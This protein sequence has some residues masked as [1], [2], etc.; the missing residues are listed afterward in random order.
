MKTTSLAPSPLLRIARLLV[1]LATSLLPVHHAAAQ[2]TALR[3]SGLRHFYSAPY[4]L[5]FN[6]A[7]R[8]Q[9]NRVV[10]LDPALF[11][12]VCRESATPISAS[13]TGFRL[14]ADNK[15]LECFVVL[16]YTLS[17]LDPV[18]NGDA[19]GDFKSD[20]VEA[21]EQGAKTLL[22]VLREDA[23]VG[24]YE[25]HRADAGF[26]PQKVADLMRDKAYLTNQI[27]GIWNEVVWTS[28]STRCWDA[29]YMA[30][31]EFPTDNPADD[32][33]FLVF[34]SD[35]KDESSTHTANEVRSL[36]Q[37]R[38]VK[39]YCVGYG[40]ELTSGPLQNLTAQTG[41]QYYAAVSPAELTQ[42]FQEV[43]TERAE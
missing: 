10:V 29:L 5:D 26:P 4:L 1:L 39:I 9:S 13:E 7:I 31:S 16:D 14:L 28:G 21:M 43:A 11:T 20:S 2:P 19:N 42:S 17:V 27:D 22:S 30:L 40:Q 33:R 12:V 8:D 25:F 18:I 36:A 3:I 38:G 34:L 32:Q 41:G 6:F 24:L 15:Q 37:N 23:E 35:G